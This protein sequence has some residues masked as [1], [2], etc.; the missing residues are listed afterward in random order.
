ML[1][2][3]LFMAMMVSFSVF[4]VAP[5]V[6]DP[7]PEYQDVA[8]TVVPDQDKEQTVITVRFTVTGENTQQVKCYKPTYRAETFAPHEVG[9]RF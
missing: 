6:V 7:V 8:A 4:A 5:R 3:L 1:K 9:W 2:V